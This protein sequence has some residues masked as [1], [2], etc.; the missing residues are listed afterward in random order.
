MSEWEEKK[1]ERE[2]AA[3]QH[4]SSPLLGADKSRL[5]KEEVHQRIGYKPQVVEQPLD[6]NNTSVTRRL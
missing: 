5:T 4:K 3:Q 6:Y 2:L 1:K